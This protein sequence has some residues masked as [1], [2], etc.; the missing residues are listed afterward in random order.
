MQSFF[1]P[2]LGPAPRWASFLE[3]L[4]EEMEEGTRVG[5]KASISAGAIYDNYKFVTKTE[6]S[7]LNLDHLIGTNVLRAYMHGYFVDLRLYEKAKSI[8]NPFAYEEYLEEQRRVK[9]EAE[10]AGRI[11]A[12]SSALQQQ[13]S[14]K[15]SGPLL[16]NGVKAKVNTVLAERLQQQSELLA[17]LDAMEAEKA[18]QVATEQ[19][20]DDD[21]SE[22]EEIVVTKAEKK[23]IQAAKSGHAILADTRFSSLFTN[24]DFAIDEETDEFRSI[25]RRAVAE[26]QI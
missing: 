21:L 24:P 17:K 18:Q 1:I 7:S 20:S 16:V 26:D 23:A 4:T 9:L 13:Q 10:R 19:H 2:A 15:K 6:L 11:K 5:G 25:V 3:N 8:A 14:K 22:E 12:N